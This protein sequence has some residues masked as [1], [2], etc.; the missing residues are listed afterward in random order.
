MVFPR[1]E[2]Q[3]RPP[4]SLLMAGVGRE[5][6]SRPDHRDLARPL[7]KL[8]SDWAIIE[9][10]VLVFRW[11]ARQ[12]F[13]DSIAWPGWAQDNRSGSPTSSSTAAPSASSACSMICFG[14]RTARLLSHWRFRFAFHFSCCRY[15]EYTTSVRETAITIFSAVVTGT[16]D[17]GRVKVPHKFAR[18]PP[19]SIEIGAACADDFGAEIR[20]RADFAL[21]RRGSGDPAGHWHAEA[22]M[23]FMTLPAALASGLLARVEPRVCKGLRPIT[24][25]VPKHRHFRQRALSLNHRPCLPSQPTALLDQLDVAVARWVGVGFGRVTRHRG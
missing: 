18:K 25:L 7:D 8:V 3:C 22:V 12:Q 5:S 23:M 4:P 2:H 11:D 13:V 14:K 17:T 24:F 10:L 16:P 21:S 19:A 9:A 15:D 20:E 1:R 6:Q